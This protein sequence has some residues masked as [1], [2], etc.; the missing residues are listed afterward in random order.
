ML[1]NRLH[2]TQ[3]QKK[4]FSLLI[5]IFTLQEMSL[6]AGKDHSV[7]DVSGSTFTTLRRAKSLDR[8]V[9]DSS[10]TV[11]GHSA[12][13]FLFFFFSSNTFKITMFTDTKIV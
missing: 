13:Q 6:D 4:Y 5:L 8:K 11:S 3:I 9:T 2:T 1:Q 7:P 12:L 10:M